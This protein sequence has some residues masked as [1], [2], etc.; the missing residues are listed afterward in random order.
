[1]RALAAFAVVLPLVCVDVEAQETAAPETPPADAQAD[2]APLDTIPVAS[3]DAPPPVPAAEPQDEAQGLAEIVVT[4]QKRKQSLHDVPISVS[5]LSG[6]L[7]KDI[8]ASNLADASTYIPN[9][10]VDADDLGSPQVFIRGFG[11]NTFNPSF[12]SSVGFVED[13]IFYGRGAYFTESMFDIDRVEV[14][15]GPQGTLFGKNTVAGLYNVITAS[16]TEQFSGNL[17]LSTG[18]YNEQRLEGGVGGMFNDWFGAR[19]AVL[20]QSGDGELYNQY[21]DRDEDKMRQ[22]AGRLKLR[23][24]PLDDVTMDVTLQRSVTD[25]NFWPYELFALD[26]GTRN[27]L[28]KFDPDI[29]DDP[30][31]FRTSF[32]QPG[33]INKN[34]ATESLKTDWAMGDLG[35]IRDAHLI[36]IG[37]YSN[38]AINQLNDL[39]VSPADL[40]RLYNYEDYGQTSAELRFSGRSDS[41]FGLGQSVDFVAGGFFFESNYKL[42]AQVAVGHD[43]GSYVLTQDAWQLIT[44]NLNALPGNIATLPILGDLLAGVIGDDAYQFDYRQ[45]LKSGALYA[46]MTWNISEHW[47]LTPGIRYNRET[48]DVD[49]AGTAHCRTAPTCLTPLLLGAKDYSHPNLK[50]DETDWSPKVALQYIWDPNLN[51]Y[52]SYARGY[53]SGGYNSLSYTGED[54]AFKPEKAGTAEVGFKGRFFERRLNFNMALYQTKLDDLQVLAFHGATTNVG[55]AS[56]TSQGLEAD[57]QWLT[58]WRMLMLNGSFGL[59]DASY[60]QYPDAPAPISQ[61]INATQDLKGKRLAFTPK[62]T[63]TLTPVLT[64][65]LGSLVARLSADAIWQGEQYTD[66]DL[67]P[68]TRVGGYMEYAA[69]LSLGSADDLWTLTVGGSNLGDKRVLNQATDAVLFPGTYYAQQS[70]GRQY[71]AALAINW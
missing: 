67:D 34:S 8:N 20:A 36:L 71:Y 47:A 50:R 15:R 19:L 29:E 46:Q 66:T 52:A 1:M 31:D 61:G 16:P 49:S 26:T 30:Y 14:L 35:G 43:I 32:D 42:R 6:D 40:L 53:K 5:A 25:I 59:I 51:V 57:F 13:E 60:D 28:D 10:R 68:H 55:N 70:A 22:K 64:L 9:V 54:L 18:Q 62:Q 44:G 41:L 69:R 21:L 63:A 24:L 7:L 2:G 37:G 38:L 48:K 11:T 23:L 27:Y 17:R 4:A 33:F 12:E 39:D 65:P 45:K 58:P 56:A 3:A